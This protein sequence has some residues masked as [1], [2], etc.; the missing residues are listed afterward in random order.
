MSL[1]DNDRDTAFTLMNRWTVDT[2]GG[3]EYGVTVYAID[4]PGRYRAAEGL[5]REWSYYLVVLDESTFS[6]YMQ[7]YGE[8]KAARDAAFEVE[9]DEYARWTLGN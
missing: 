3:E 8:D 9:R 4:K 6:T 5:P 1:I 2:T 7:G